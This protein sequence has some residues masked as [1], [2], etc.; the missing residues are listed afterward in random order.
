MFIE[1]VDLLTIRV[2]YVNHHIYHVG[3]DKTDEL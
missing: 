3:L 2:N 1:K